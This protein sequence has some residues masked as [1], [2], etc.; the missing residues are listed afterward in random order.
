M[1][2]IEQ[3]N[4]EAL[5]VPSLFV[6]DARTGDMEMFV[7]YLQ[8]FGK[9]EE[10]C[11]VWHEDLLTTDEKGFMSFHFLLLVKALKD[12]DIGPLNFKSLSEEKGLNDKA[13]EV[14]VDLNRSMFEL[15]GKKE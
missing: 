7:S 13:K 2:E 8:R 4:E 3:F 9:L 10:W 11:A 14:I 6:F 12:K 1:S 5:K 15:H